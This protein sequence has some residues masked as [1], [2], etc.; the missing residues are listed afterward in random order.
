MYSLVFR[1]EFDKKFNKIKDKNL[2]KQIQLKLLQLKIH[3]PIGKKLVNTNYFRIRVRNYRIVYEIF[4]NSKT[5]EV[6]TIL[7]RGHEYRDL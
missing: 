2:K 1:V 3:N 6:I 5:I 4:E 7:K